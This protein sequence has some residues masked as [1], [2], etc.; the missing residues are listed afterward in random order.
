MALHMFAAIYIG[1]YEVSLKIFEF[2]QK[3]RNHE[4]DHIRSRLDLGRDVFTEGSIGYERVDELCDTLKEFLHIMQGYKV[5]KYEVYASTVIRDASNEL[6]VLDQI[7]LRTGIHVKVI[8]NSEHRFISYKSVAGRAPFEKMIQTSAAVVDVGGAGIQVTLIRKGQIIT[9]QYMDIGTIRL[10]SIMNEGYTLQHYEMQMEEYI[11]KNIEVFRSLYLSEGMD[12]CIFMNDYCME[13]VKKMEKN[14]QEEDLIRSDKFVKFI[15]KLLKKN[16][17]EISAELNLSNDRDPLIVPSM[18]LFKAI[19]K[20]LGVKEIWVP[21]MNINDGIAYDYAQR[22]RLVQE[23]HDFE[24][25]ILSAS[26]NLS[27]HYHSYSPHTEALAVLSV[28][29]YDTMKK[30]HGLGKRERLLLQVASIL[31]DCGKYVS[32][33]DS[34]VCTYHIIMA[35]E[36]IGLSHNEREIVALTVLYNTLPLDDYSEL[37]D[38][39]DQDSYLVVAKLSAILRVANALDQS[40]KQKYQK[41]RVSTKGRELVFTVETMNDISLEQGLFEA[42]TLYFENV[43]SMKPVIKVKRVYGMK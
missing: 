27:K 19:V 2:S 36:I 22:N 16:L 33:S 3:K 43:F 6:F 13:L 10:R 18:L 1:S 25:D 42:K 26:V 11:N 39:I 21:G 15:D 34:P 14:H 31:H 8:S 32:I 17:E 7:F 40:H 23:A 29:I 30:V 28:Q 12:Y 35:S 24:A 41:I 20:N 37:Y 4:I 9:T 38:K 5:E